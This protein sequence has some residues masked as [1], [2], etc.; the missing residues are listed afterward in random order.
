MSCNIY[1]KVNFDHDIFFRVEYKIKCKKCF[2][3]FSKTELYQMYVIEKITEA[4]NHE[5]DID[6]ENQF[7]FFIKQI[8]NQCHH[9]KCTIS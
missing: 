7:K 6:L 4:Y 2:D 5:Y 1:S 3:I 9:S 8:N